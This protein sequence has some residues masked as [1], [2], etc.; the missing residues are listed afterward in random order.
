VSDDMQTAREVSTRLPLA[1][2]TL[3]LLDHVTADDFLGEVFDR[4]RGRSYEAALSFPTFV[5]L[6]ADAL[7]EHDGCARQS[8]L[9]ARDQG[10]LGASFEAVYGKLRRVPL[11]LSKG[12][13]FE[14]SRRLLGLFPEAA[15]TALPASLAGMHLLAVDGKKVKHV[16]R[17]MKV[18]RH[19]LGQIYGG[20]L[21]VALSVNT[22]LAVA[23]D[24]HPD[25]E[26]GDTPLL[27]G[28]LRQVRQCVDGSRSPRLWIA[29][30]LFCDLDQP[31]LFCQGG[32][33]F[34][35]RYNRRVSFRPDAAGDPDRARREGKD[36]R[37]G[38]AYVEEWGWIG[39]EGDPRR[40][41][42]RRVT[43]SRPGDPEGD[44]A[45]ITDLLDGRLYPAQDIL[46]AYL[47][48]WEIEGCFQQITE[49]FTLRRLI[50]STPEATVYQA[51][52][53]LLLYDVL[54]VVRGYVAEAAR[55]ETEEVSTEQMF[56]DMQRQLIAWGE[57]MTAEETVR[58]LEGYRQ[59]DLAGRLR[60]LAQAMWQHRWAKT[61]N[62]P[63]AGG[64]PPQK[65]G[66][67]QME[68]PDGGHTSIFRLL[69]RERSS[70]HDKQSL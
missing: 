14:S 69:Q 3:R 23:L 6:I 56:N 68:Y 67:K 40:R 33:H 34:I 5:R 60:L 45:L 59:E 36:A 9:H 12:F 46:E 53:C 24:A 44:V 4:Y 2:A 63:K 49:V 18:A 58:L 61:T 26:T 32:D 30:R 47:L 10:E 19:V 42:V 41:Y 8:F 11:S 52:F 65:R 28:V 38:R 35:I 57:V 21:V 51:A 43:L 50:S 27:P 62:K 55:K 17:R 31:G 20:K 7:L 39:T 1:E 66:Q 70:N 37:S 29:D 54:L 16:A 48:R 25:G 15:K 64:R 22:R 13:L